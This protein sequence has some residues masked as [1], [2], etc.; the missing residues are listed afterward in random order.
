MIPIAVYIL[1]ALTSLACAFLLIRSYLNNRT[2]LLFW[3]AI[4]FVGFFI[5]NVILVFDLVVLPPEIDLGLY[6]AIA[7]LGSGVVL[8]YGLISEMTS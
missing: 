2:G 3:S 4:C 6:R 7:N 1:C 5:A 8:L